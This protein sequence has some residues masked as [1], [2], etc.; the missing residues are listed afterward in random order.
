MSDGNID[1]AKEVLRQKGLASAKKIVKGLLP[2][3]LQ[4]VVFVPVQQVRCSKLRLILRSTKR[5]CQKLVRTSD[6]LGA[7]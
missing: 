7:P 3:V 5:E 2:K 4:K 6:M 1:L